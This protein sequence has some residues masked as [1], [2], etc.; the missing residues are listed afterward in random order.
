MWQR[1]DKR[2]WQWLSAAI[3]VDCLA[4]PVSSPAE[5]FTVRYMRVEGL[6][7]ISEGTVFN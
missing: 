7:R 5:E 3:A 1:Q 4:F 2:L 6:Q